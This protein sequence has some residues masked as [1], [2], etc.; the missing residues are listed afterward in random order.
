MFTPSPQNMITPISWR[1]FCYT[2]T[3]SKFKFIHYIKFNKQE[4]ENLITI[5]RHFLPIYN[6]Y[7]RKTKKYPDGYDTVY[8]FVLVAI[9]RYQYNDLREL[10]KLDYIRILYNIYQ[11]FN[12]FD[13]HD[14]IA[15]NL[16][17]AVK[18]T[19]EYDI[20]YRIL[21]T[22]PLKIEYPIIDYSEL[23]NPNSV[24]N[25]DQYPIKVKDQLTGNWFEI[26]YNVIP[27][28]G[29]SLWYSSEKN[30][31][32][33][34]KPNDVICSYCDDYYVIDEEIYRD[35]ANRTATRITYSVEIN[36]NLVALPVHF[37]NQ[38]ELNENKEQT[39]SNLGLMANAALSQIKID[40]LNSLAK[41]KS[42]YNQLVEKKSNAK[43]THPS[44][45]VKGT[46]NNNN[47]KSR[48]KLK[49]SQKINPGD[50]ILV[51]YGSQALNE[52][53]KSLLEHDDD[54]TGDTTESD[55]DIND[56]NP[57]NYTIVHNYNGKEIDITDLSKANIITKSM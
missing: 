48:I 12:I 15:G 21:D 33:P 47:K 51:A 11:E 36:K 28:S 19:F 13:I 34:L 56:N 42:K 26:R 14:Y 16:L 27:N 32:K 38:I 1:S 31:N 30:N 22:K 52:L 2:I 39:S 5:K 49:T 40:K 3:T 25:K 7:T 8:L 41:N 29:R 9:L 54:H 24:A 44:I 46:G 57:N 43:I 45:K 4:I 23:F 10:L 18:F 35:L 20:Y 6:Y 55:S 53:F 17:L 37:G 50:E